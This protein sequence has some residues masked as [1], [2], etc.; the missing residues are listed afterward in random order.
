MSAMK[1]ELITCAIIVTLFAIMIT[2]LVAQ[3]N[4]R[5]AIPDPTGSAEAGYCA[6]CSAPKAPEGRTRVHPRQSRPPTVKPSPVLARA[7][8]LMPPD[9]AS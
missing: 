4:W 6:D 1:A 5:D 2:A 3:E 8:A 9:G 7:A